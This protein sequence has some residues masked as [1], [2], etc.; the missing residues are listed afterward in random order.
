MQEAKKARGG[1]FYLF[2]EG[3]DIGLTNKIRAYALKERGFDTY[4]ANRMLGLPDDNREY[5]IVGEALGDFNVKEVVLMTNN[6][7]K[8]KAI[9]AMGIKVRRQSHEV[10]PNSHNEKYL[11]SKKKHG[12]QLKKV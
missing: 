7:S 1:I 4:E 3:R 2:Q 12:H 6:P 5:R 8:I 10:A 9:E 11:K